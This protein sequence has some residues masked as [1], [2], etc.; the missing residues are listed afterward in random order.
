MLS[1]TASPTGLLRQPSR[2]RCRCYG[3]AHPPYSDLGRLIALDV[4]FAFS[5][6]RLAHSA[7]S[8]LHVSSN[9]RSGTFCA[10]PGNI[11]FTW[12]ASITTALGWQ[13]LLSSARR[14]TGSCLHA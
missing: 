1:L 3:P 5:F 4:H 7:P 11:P 12:P 10:M 2:L 8:A 6:N 14:N 9:H 13:S